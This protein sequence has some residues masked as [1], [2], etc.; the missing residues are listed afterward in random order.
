MSETTIL[1]SIKQLLEGIKQTH[2][3][4]IVHQDIKP[5]NIFVHN[6]IVKLGDLGCSKVFATT[7]EEYDRFD[8]SGTP[9]Y[10]PPEVYFL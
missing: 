6:G 3:M 10:M 8:Y 2:D 9:C 4:D 7:N 1:S 5:A